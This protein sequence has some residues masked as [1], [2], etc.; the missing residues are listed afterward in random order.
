[1]LSVSVWVVIVQ[2]GSQYG[3]TVVDPV[4]LE[5]AHH[6]LIKTRWWIGDYIGRGIVGWVK[7]D[8]LEC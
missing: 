2:Y 8:L 1:M 5:V 4:G 7:E 6:A 3:C